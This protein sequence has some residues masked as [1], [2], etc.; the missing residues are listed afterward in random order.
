MVRLN[1]PKQLNALNQELS[2]TLISTLKEVDHDEGIRSIVIAGGDK[3]FA[4][5][6]SIC[7]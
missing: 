3:A 7:R 1:R 6:G 4:G 2:K 5:M